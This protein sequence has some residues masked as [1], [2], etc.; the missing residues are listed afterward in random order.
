MVREKKEM[1]NGKAKTLS[2]QSNDRVKGE[3]ERKERV[4][5]GLVLL[6]A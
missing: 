1:L 6:V 5:T 2:D 4:Y 3:T